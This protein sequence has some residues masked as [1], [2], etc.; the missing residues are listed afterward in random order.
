MHKRVFLGTLLGLFLLATASFAKELNLQV[1]KA[2]LLNFDEEI[3]NVNADEKCLDAQILHTIFSD[4]TQLVVSLKKDKNSFLQVKTENNFYNYEI[5]SA[6]KS[7]EDAVEID[8]PPV[9]NFDVDIY[10]GGN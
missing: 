7:S 3:L 8:F 1:G 9:E 5:K 6:A 10:T 4:K 2:Y